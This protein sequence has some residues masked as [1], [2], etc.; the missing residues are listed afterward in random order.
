MMAK[1][2]RNGRL[3]VQK[4]S[5]R[6]RIES[7][8][9]DELNEQTFTDFVS[10]KDRDRNKD[11]GEHKETSRNLLSPVSGTSSLG[12]EKKYRTTKVH[13]SEIRTPVV[14]RSEEQTSEVRTQPSS[15]WYNVPRSTK[16]QVPRN[17]R[18]TSDLATTSRDRNIKRDARDAEKMRH[19]KAAREEAERQEAIQQEALKKEAAREEALRKK[20]QGSSVV[21]LTPFSFITKTPSSPIYE[22]TKDLQD[23]LRRAALANSASR[24][25]NVLPHVLPLTEGNLAS[26]AQCRERMQRIEASLPPPPDSW[27]SSY[28]ALG[29]T[30]A[31]QH[32]AYNIALSIEAENKNN[33]CGKQAA[34]LVMSGPA[35]HLLGEKPVFIWNKHDQTAHMIDSYGDSGGGTSMKVNDVSDAGLLRA[36]IDHPVQERET[37]SS[38]K[39]H[40]DTYRL[41]TELDAL[42]KQKLSNYAEQLQN[43]K[44][45]LDP[46]D[47][48]LPDT[49]AIEVSRDKHPKVN[50]W[51]DDQ[52]Q[53]PSTSIAVRPRSSKELQL[54]VPREESGQPVVMPREFGAVLVY[55][56][57]KNHYDLMVRGK[58]GSDSGRLIPVEVPETG[59]NNFYAALL[60]AADFN[61]G[62]DA[63]RPISIE[64]IN[65][66]KAQIAQDLR[67]NPHRLLEARGLLNAMPDDSDSEALWPPI[68]K[69]DETYFEE[70]LRRFNSTVEGTPKT[71]AQKSREFQYK[72]KEDQ[73][74]EK[75]MKKLGAA[76]LPPGGGGCRPSSSSSNS[77]ND[78]HDDR[79]GERIKKM[80]PASQRVPSAAL[81]SIQKKSSDSESSKVNNN[82]KTKK[83]SA[84]LAVEEDLEDI[85][86]MEIDTSLPNK[87]AL[88]VPVNTSNRDS[89]NVS[90]G[91]FEND[92]RSENFS[93]VVSDFERFSE[94]ESEKDSEQTSVINSE[95]Q[96]LKQSVTSDLTDDL[97]NDLMSDLTSDLNARSDITTSSEKTKTVDIDIKPESPS[98]LPQ[99][100]VNIMPKAIRIL[101]ND[102]E[103]IQKDI[104]RALQLMTQKDGAK[105]S[106]NEGSQ[107]SSKNNAYRAAL[108]WLS[109]KNEGYFLI[110]SALMDMMND[111]YGATPAMNALQARSGEYVQLAYISL[112]NQLANTPANAKLV[113][114]LLRS[115]GKAPGLFGQ[116]IPGYYASII[117]KAS[118]NT[119]QALGALIETLKRQLGN[120]D[121]TIKKIS[122]E[123]S[124]YLVN[125]QTQSKSDLPALNEVD[126]EG[127]LQRIQND[128]VDSLPKIKN[129]YECQ[130]VHNKSL[131]DRLASDQTRARA[132]VP[133]TVQRK[134]T[135]GDIISK[136]L[137]ESIKNPEARLINAKQAQRQ[138][139]DSASWYRQQA[140]RNQSRT[141]E[142][143]DRERLPALT[144]RLHDERG[145]QAGPSHQAAAWDFMANDVR[146]DIRADD[147]TDERTETAQEESNVQNTFQFQNETPIMEIETP[148]YVQLEESPPP[149]ERVEVVEQEAM[150]SASNSASNDASMTF[151]SKE[152]GPSYDPASGG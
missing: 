48:R 142:E 10:A 116:T 67:E 104:A 45:E 129:E 149:E 93:V 132:S 126:V 117:S 56:K 141:I 81:N 29:I 78:D 9:R 41:A 102:I 59:P 107:E 109:N 12:T 40:P 21:P 123:L 63:S 98:A 52:L 6:E 147:R 28:R 87:D 136:S 39:T 53:S 14:R 99:K 106:N 44:Y 135:L 121:A 18:K 120:D 64:E 62:L 5:Y 31:L 124:K 27:C 58:T 32:T 84:P 70:L 7:Q 137:A 1:Q 74:K 20:Y 110:Q 51:L 130:Q 125:A 71:D 15:P 122:K 86:D 49:R 100:A 26:M 75:D 46:Y 77:D 24:N 105:V 119:I 143:R 118:Q 2:D 144:L 94:S 96:N 151:M 30:P 17:T 37:T 128:I 25:T 57:N 80:L 68:E 65:A 22:N 76:F 47:P 11:K 145:G 138:A 16:N 148:S 131:A 60:R 103:N 43:S 33:M 108:S 55:D 79:G 3:V 127:A 72:K 36:V 85:D 150:N 13:T 95:R 66:L 88:N 82:T 73:K 97:K 113:A 112:L 134:M 146:T 91:D 19:L 54:A 69:S 92:S 114:G 90:D 101:S 23:N 4:F 89:G 152:D 133:S 139:R 83:A 61:N 50:S 140:E 42:K 34:L 8:A 111:L 35:N 38:Q 115:P